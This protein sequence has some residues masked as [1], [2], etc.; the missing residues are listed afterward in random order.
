MNPGEYNASLV[1]KTTVRCPVVSGYV[2][3]RF[4]AS[5]WFAPVI[6]GTPATNMS[7]LFENTGQTTFSV[8]L[9]E[10]DDRS[11][12]G[13][14]Y[15]LVGFSGTAAYLRPGGQKTVNLQGRRKFLEVYCT[16]T[17][18]GELRLQIE[19]QRQWTEMGMDRTDPFYPPSLWQ[20]KEVP[21]PLS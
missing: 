2:T 19:S 20:A 18:T 16:G 13:T 3:A 17:T 12:S 14:R 10:T 11:A 6:S 7:C 8:V 4:Q 9:N 5:D 15:P 1:R 21:G